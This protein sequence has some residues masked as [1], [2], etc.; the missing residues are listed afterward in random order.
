[1]LY[2]FSLKIMHIASIY[3]FF[4]FKYFLYIFD[5][6]NTVPE[7]YERL[8]FVSDMLFQSFTGKIINCDKLDVF[9]IHL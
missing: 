7:M 2:C 5:T 1:M 6:K 9:M 4:C 8:H 3:S